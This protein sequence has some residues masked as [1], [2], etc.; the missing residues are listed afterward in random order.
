MQ[1]RSNKKSPDKTPTFSLKTAVSEQLA[2]EL[3]TASGQLAATVWRVSQS[4]LARLLGVS[5]QAVWELVRAGS[6]ETGEDGLIDA[7]LA[8]AQ[9]LDR[10]SR[11]ARKALLAPTHE[12][13]AQIRK[14]LDQMHQL[15]DD[16][17]RIIC[18]RD[19]ALRSLAELLT[20]EQAR[21]LLERRPFDRLCEQLADWAWQCLGSE[22]APD[23]WRHLG[24][25]QEFRPTELF[26][27]HSDEA[28][29]HALQREGG[30]LADESNLE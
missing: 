4:E 6:I 18:E 10:G 16:G 19:F 12:A 29:R 2:L 3:R 8:V 24:I 11:A 28:A 25:H 13:L 21:A 20:S 26:P 23:P 7:R 14:Q 17:E 27:S 9:L 22:K 15:V 5:R 1:S 30:F